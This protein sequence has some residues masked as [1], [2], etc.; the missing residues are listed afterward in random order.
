MAVKI[1]DGGIVIRASLDS[2]ELKRDAK[3]MVKDLEDLANVKVTPDKESQ[4]KFIEAL[5]HARLEAAK[6]KAEYESLSAQYVKGEIGAQQYRLEVAKLNQQR[7][8]EARQA[9]EVKKALLENSSYRKLDNELKTLRATSKDLL[10]E[11]VRLERQ[12]LKNSEAYRQ[13]ARESNNLVGKTMTLDRQMK[14]IDASVGQNYRNVGNYGDAISMVAPQLSQFTGR[15]GLLGLAVAGVNQSF[16]SNLRMEPITQSLKFASGSATE[17]QKNLDFLRESS[18]RL[19]L[20]FISTATSFK[21]WQ[22]AAKFSNLTATESRGIFESVANASAKMKLSNEQVQGT[23]LALSQIMSKGKVQAEELRGQLGERLPGAFSLAARAMGVTEVELNKM[24]EKGEVLAS[25]FLPRFAAQLDISF[26]NDKKERIEGMQASVNRLKNEFDALWQSE[27]AGKFFSTISDGLATLTSNFNKFINSGS[28]REFFLRFAGVFSSSPFQQGVSRMFGDA[29]QAVDKAGGNG[30]RG[31]VSYKEMA[32]FYKLSKDKQKEAIKAQETIVNLQT[33]EYKKNKENL[34]IRES[35][36]WNAEKLA[37]MRSKVGSDPV[38]NPITKGDGSKDKNG[39]KAA[40]RA[41][42]RERQS[43]ERQRSL[44]AQI[45]DLAEKATRKQI[46]RDEEEIASISDKYDKIR[47]EVEKFYRDPKNKGQRVDVGK[48]ASAERFEKSEAKTRQETRDLLKD[49]SDQKALY[50]EFN[51]YVEQSGKDSAEKIFGDKSEAAQTYRKNLEKE[52]T[53]LNALQLSS[54]FGVGSFTQAQREKYEELSKLRKTEISNE[55]AQ[56]RKKTDDA[57]KLA[58]N[59]NDKRLEIERQYQ[60]ARK[61]LGSNITPEQE[62]ELQKRKAKDVST[63]A[64]TELQESGAWSNLFA[65]LDRLTVEQIEKL[66]EEIETQF[67]S[68]SVNF[69]PVDLAAIRKRLEEAKDIIIDSNPFK[70]IGESLNGIFKGASD[71]S[72][73]SSDDIKNHWKS[74]AKATDKSFSFINSAVDS[75]GFLR[76]ILG[77]TGQAALET[78]Q[79]VST[80]AVGVALAIKGVE[81]SS[82]ILAVI[83]AALTALQAVFGWLDRAAKK[84][85]EELKKEQEYYEALSDTFDILIDKQKELLEENSGRSALEAYKE[86]LDLIGAKQVANRKGLEA[87]FAQGASWKSHSNWYKYDKELGKVLDRHKLL[88]FTGEDWENLLKNQYEIWAK[89]PEEVK[90]YAQS[91]MDAKEETEDLK[92]AIQESLTGFNVDDL[93]GDLEQLFSKADLSI[94]DISDSF[95]KNMK[96]AVIRLIQDESMSKGMKIWYENL[97]NALEDQT[98]TESETNDLKGQYESLVL[99]AKKRYDAAM[100]LIGFDS[101]EGGS[102]SSG[103]SIGRQ[104]TEQTGNEIVG[105]YRSGYDIWKQQLTQLQ[106]LSNGQ[107]NCIRTANA[108][109]SQLNSININTA[110]TAEQ[111]LLI[112]NNTA[113]ALSHLKNIDRNT[114]GRYV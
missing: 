11:M 112:A 97:V 52:F 79:A 24:L 89:L 12:G 56:E 31:L 113:S 51:S 29:Q 40:E 102:L 30:E 77:E 6:S 26:G 76:D 45:D 20:E 81:N 87:W 84:R 105:M 49:L 4:L 25:D 48:L 75:A 15:L 88:N 47:A 111:A 82:V 78:L 43:L 85:N 22:G 2:S 72:D 10:A 63:L 98:L 59:F 106:M 58:Q 23:F 17:F 35:M 74:L 65:D 28:V 107:N 66:I 92:I 86:A 18:D 73:K 44:Q 42:E 7:K 103:E 50:D 39:K 70:Q 38:L 108:Q 91:V 61:R 33:E 53:M 96:K 16:N 80:A 3:N 69:N 90:N 8:E 41:A 21:L 1:I 9:R 104:L 46:S 94:K 60:E 83:Q 34:K 54:Q 5:R 110:K 99:E 37:K 101:S 109:L 55:A 64:A 68:L 32:D 57:I 27:R 71:D 36:L 13:L 100:D 14:S 114:S 19:G 62:Q 95:Y 93:K 67:D